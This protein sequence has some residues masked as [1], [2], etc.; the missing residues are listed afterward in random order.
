MQRGVKRK[1]PATA[2][3]IAKRSRLELTS[4]LIRSSDT[5]NVK[6]R[7]ALFEQALQRLTDEEVENVYSFA[8]EKKLVVLGN[9]RLEL[10][11]ESLF[12]KL[13][14]FLD[15]RDLASCA[16]ASRS[17]VAPIRRGVG[18][19]HCWPPGGY[20]TP[21]AINRFKD[22]GLLP[23]R[24]TCRRITFDPENSDVVEFVARLPSI[25]EVQLLGP[26]PLSCAKL[27]K[28]A[29]A[30]VRSL[31]FLGSIDSFWLPPFRRVQQRIRVEDPQSLVLHQLP[32]LSME[33]M[34]DLSACE[35]KSDGWTWKWEWPSPVGFSFGVDHCEWKN[36][37][38][39]YLETN[40]ANIALSLHAVL[41]FLRDRPVPTINIR[42][43]QSGEL[44][45]RLSS[46]PTFVKLSNLR[47]S[48][49]ALNPRRLTGLSA[50]S[51]LV[52]QECVM[53]VDGSQVQANIADEDTWMQ[54]A[55]GVLHT[56]LA[57]VARGMPKL[58]KLVL[59]DVR[60][61]FRL[62]EIE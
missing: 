13:F 33:A 35:L 4:D 31:N 27:L 30:R 38:G 11:P 18:V 8:D 20:F 9:S 16:A 5:K 54:E 17:V 29:F 2:P 61:H 22:R 12:D 52:L 7:R 58:T 53:V 60:C 48:G 51:C 14:E 32:L 15:H 46:I 41:P 42:C 55:R 39:L 57:E 28:P 37:G 21:G 50:L 19:R 24:L 45:T 25:R 3:E 36:C 62:H 6:H 1:S 59:Y 23:E 40:Y 49:V 34:P 47:L 44:W 26:L 43:V 10:L 56:E